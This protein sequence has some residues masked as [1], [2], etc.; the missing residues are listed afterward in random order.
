MLTSRG[1]R[2]ISNS[3]GQLLRPIRRRTYRR[4]AC[5]RPFIFIAA[6]SS[7]SSRNSLP[8][9]ACISAWTFPGGLPQR[10]S[11]QFGGATEPQREAGPQRGTVVHI[12]RHAV[13]V[14]T[15]RDIA[16]I[17]ARGQPVDP[18]Y[19]AAVRVSG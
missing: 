4:S 14:V 1:G 17:G 11:R 8:S 16:G 18:Q 13:D 2:A 10:D 6:S 9:P 15:T 5:R 19:Q 3:G 12:Q 7:W